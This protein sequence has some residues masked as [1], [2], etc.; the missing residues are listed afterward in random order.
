MKTKNIFRSAI[1][2]ALSVTLMLSSVAF[3]AEPPAEESPAVVP[4]AITEGHGAIQVLRMVDDKPIENAGVSIYRVGNLESG[5]PSW[6][7]EYAGYKLTLKPSD[8]ETFSVLPQNL[9]TVIRRDNKE[10]LK[11]GMT[12]SD[13]K[14]S[15]S[16]LEDGLY[17]VTGDRY[18]YSGY[19]YD[20]IPF[21]VFMPYLTEEQA[22]DRD[23]DLEIKHTATRVPSSGGDSTVSRKVLKVWDDES[24]EEQRPEYVTVQLLNGEKVVDTQS[25]SAANN[26]RFTWTNLN[27]NGDWSVAEVDVPEHYSAST[28]REGVTF[29]VTNTFEEDVE[30]NPTPETENPEESQPPVV[31]TPGPEV[32]PGP[33]TTPEPVVTPPNEDT[34]IPDE[35]PPHSGLPQTG[36]L[37]MPVLMCSGSGIAFIVTGLIMKRKE[38]IDE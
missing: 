36:Q 9:V 13:G 14:V 33:D 32:T 17:L 11:T 19:Y 18:Q 22:L 31:E 5:V 26:W 25:L 23:I 4:P 21:L 1:M 20:P 34:D 8:E 27:R 2:T 38:Q 30:D 29:V 24:N 37:W 16:D 6:T 15:F 12:N 28:K 3:A 10:A 35:N 7:E